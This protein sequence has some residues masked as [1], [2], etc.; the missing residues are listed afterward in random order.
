MSSISDPGVSLPDFDD[1]LRAQEAAARAAEFDILKLTLELDHPLAESINTALTKLIEQHKGSRELSV[2]INAHYKRSKREI[3][4]RK[5]T[6]KTCNEKL[7]KCVQE[8]KHTLATA[9]EYRVTIKILERKFI[10]KGGSL[11]GL[12]AAVYRDINKRS[13]SV[14]P[15]R[16]SLRSSSAG[17]L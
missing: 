11:E 13:A 16:L 12:K 2:N 1:Q 15:R 10:E 5:A 4:A 17:V 6:V 7:E 14:P 8:K 9:K 3:E